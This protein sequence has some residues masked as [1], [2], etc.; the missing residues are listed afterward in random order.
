MVIIGAAT[1]KQIKGNGQKNNKKP[2]GLA[3]NCR[4]CE[5]YR[6]HTCMGTNDYI[7]NPGRK[8]C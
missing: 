5:L 1:L 4:E 7:N 2:R 3:A 6:N 8:N